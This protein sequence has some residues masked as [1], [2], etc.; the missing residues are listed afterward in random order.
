MSSGPSCKDVQTLAG[1]RFN[2]DAVP[3]RSARQSYGMG[4]AS[5]VGIVDSGAAEEDWHAI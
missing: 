5:P 2:V 3:M 1:R 4:V